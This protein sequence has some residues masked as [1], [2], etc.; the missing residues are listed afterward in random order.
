MACNDCIVFCDQ[1]RT[2]E[3]NTFDVRATIGSVEMGSRDAEVPHNAGGIQVA[4][5]VLRNVSS[6]DRVAAEKFR[7]P[8]MQWCFERAAPVPLIWQKR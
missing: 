2:T 4:M 6:V 7:P 3:A 5:D 8:L 1:H